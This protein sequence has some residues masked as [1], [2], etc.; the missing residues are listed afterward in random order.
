MSPQFHI[1]FRHIHSLSQAYDSL[2]RLYESHTSLY[3]SQ[4]NSHPR[5]AEAQ[6]ILIQGAAPLEP[7]MKCILPSNRERHLRSGSKALMTNYT[8][9]GMLLHSRTTKLAD[10]NRSLGVV[11][12]RLS[13]LE[14]QFGDALA[15][16]RRLA[17]APPA[18]PPE[19]TPAQNWRKRHVPDDSPPS[20]EAKR[21]RIHPDATH[22]QHTATSRKFFNTKAKMTHELLVVY[23]V[24]RAR[25]QRKLNSSASP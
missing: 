23:N 3:A 4:G 16:L 22:R 21:Q 24:K 5:T 9:Q 14:D 7:L 8:N 10:S 12:T 17:T 25:R 19:K 18:I 11:E 1:R 20:P 6:V 13:R 2:V 15:L